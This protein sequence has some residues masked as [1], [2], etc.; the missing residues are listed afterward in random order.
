MKP[1]GHRMGEIVPFVGAG[2]SRSEPGATTG[3]PDGKAL[4]DELAALMPGSVALGAHDNLAKVAQFFQHTVFDRDAVYEFLHRRLETEQAKAA[5]GAVTRM[6]AGIP[7]GSTPLFFITT[8]YD[9]FIER[10]FRAD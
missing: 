10:A 4:A 7:N 1:R 5:P 9:S 3:V 2:A 6:L 8:S